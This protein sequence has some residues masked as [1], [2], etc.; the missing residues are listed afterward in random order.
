MRPIPSKLL[1]SALVLML[2]GAGSAAP[3]TVWTT[4]DGRRQVAQWEGASG[5]SVSLRTKKGV[6]LRIK[7]SDLSESAEAQLQRFSEVPVAEMSLQLAAYWGDLERVKSLLTAGAGVD[8]LGE[9]PF[10]EADGL[11]AKPAFAPLHCAAQ[12]GQVE[13]AAFLLQSGAEVNLP[14][15]VRGVTPL[16]EAAENGH[17]DVAQ[18]LIRSGA[19]FG[20]MDFSGHTPLS[21][22]I[23]LGA[24]AE[25][26]DPWLEAFREV[27]DVLI[28]QDPDLNA[29][30]EF[31]LMDPE[32]GVLDFARE[33]GNAAAVAI[34]QKHGARYVRNPEILERCNAIGL[35][36]FECRDAA[37][38][39]VVGLINQRAKAGDPSGTGVKVVLRVDAAGQRQI[40]PLTF[41]FQNLPLDVVLRYVAE[42]AG[43]ACE[44]GLSEVA[45]VPKQSRGAGKLSSWTDI[46]GAVIRAEFIR[47]DGETLV[48]RKEGREFRIPMARLSEDSRKQAGALSEGEARSRIP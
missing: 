42:M 5:G 2:G 27:L 30:R 47:L 8:E 29:R 10:C 20:A 48:I 21:R 4:K 33:S 22:V 18:L 15:S 14:S 25:L 35:G 41:Q 16:H 11:A 43:L 40:A 36:D 37:I 28:K 39:R 12:G 45:L 24:E 26:A 1:I 34:L 13:L 17:A 46:S 44:Y 19:D 6:L 38:G 23:E 32:R 7:R 9:Q 31:L 3:Y